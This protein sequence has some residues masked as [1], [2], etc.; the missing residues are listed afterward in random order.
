MGGIGGE[1]NGRDRGMGGIG[2]EGDGRDRGRG[3]W[4]G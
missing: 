3:R 4:E 1:G 2:G